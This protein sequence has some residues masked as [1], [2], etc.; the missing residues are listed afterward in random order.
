MTFFS[1]VKPGWDGCQRGVN[2]GWAGCQRGVAPGW[3]EL[4]P[5]YTITADSWNF[6]Q[7]GLAN[8]VYSTDWEWSQWLLVD[9]NVDNATVLTADSRHAVISTCFQRSS[10]PLEASLDNSR[11]GQLADTAST[12]RCLLL[13]LFSNTT[14]KMNKKTQ[15][16]KPTGKP[17]PTKAFEA[18]VFLHIFTATVS[19]SFRES[20]HCISFAD[21]PIC[22]WSSG[23]LTDILRYAEVIKRY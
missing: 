22:D 6:S 12:G 20:P 3:A 19:G 4:G 1:G 10:H 23:T 13:W 17:K 21:W 9:I 11:T 7:A 18:L 16:K 8:R 5:W 15:I 14:S 2:P